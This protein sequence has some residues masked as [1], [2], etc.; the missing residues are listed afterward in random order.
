MKEGIFCSLTMAT[1]VKDKNAH[2]FALSDAAVMLLSS[3][4][5]VWKG[6]NVGGPSTSG[7]DSLWNLVPPFLQRKKGGK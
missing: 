6:K 5:K 4:S 2:F 1:K 3:L 7:E